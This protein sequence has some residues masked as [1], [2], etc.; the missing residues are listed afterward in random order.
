MHQRNFCKHLCGKSFAVVAYHLYARDEFRF[1][2]PRPLCGLQAVFIDVR[3]VG[4]IRSVDNNP[5]AARNKAHYVVAGDGIT[6]VRKANQQSAHTFNRHT[7]RGRILKL[8]RIDDLDRLGNFLFIIVNQ[9]KNY[10]IDA[11][12]PIADRCH[13]FVN[14][15]ENK[16]VGKLFEGAFRKDVVKAVPAA[17]RLGFKHGFAC[18]YVFLL[19]SRLK[20]SRILARAEP[21]LTNLSQSHEG[22]RP[23]D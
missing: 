1:H 16:L 12:G 15:A 21:D 20:K 10:L 18:F 14:G 11:H 7:A 6:A 5:S 8:A 2:Q 3:K 22:P 4:A 17:A 13:H 19:H 23:L 9:F